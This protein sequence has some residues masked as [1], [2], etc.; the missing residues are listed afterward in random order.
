MIERIKDTS[1]II[2]SGHRGYKSAYPVNTLLAFREA[3]DAGVDIWNS[4]CG[5]PRTMS[6]SSIMTIRWIVRLTERAACAI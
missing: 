1:S 5:C 6:S 2:I 3:L 4:N